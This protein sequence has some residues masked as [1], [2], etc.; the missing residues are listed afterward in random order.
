MILETI[1]GAA[2]GSAI[3]STIGSLVRRS[4]KPGSVANVCSCIHGY[5]IHEDGKACKGQIERDHPDYL[6]GGREWV[7]CPCTLYDGPEPL[8]RVWST[9]P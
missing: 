3:G 8:P 4:K 2:I 6:G 5:G 7:P 9:N 1:L